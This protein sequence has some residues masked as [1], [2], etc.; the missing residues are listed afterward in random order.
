MLGK[1]QIDLDALERASEIYRENGELNLPKTNHDQINRIL[2]NI[3]QGYERE[4]L[5]KHFVERRLDF[6]TESLQLGYLAVEEQQ[7]EIDGF[8]RELFGEITTI[9]QFFN[10]IYTEHTEKVK[11]AIVSNEF[12][13]EYTI[14]LKDGRYLPIRHIGKKILDKCISIMMSIDT[15][16]Q[17]HLQKE[18]ILERYEL[19]NQAMTE[20]PY[21]MEIPVD[22]NELIS[23]ANTFWWSPQYRQMLGYKDEN[24]FPNELQSWLNILHPEDAD[25]AYKAMMDYLSD[26]S[27]KTDYQAI[28]RMMHK[29]G[30]YYWYQSEGVVKRDIT[31]RPTRLAGTVRNVQHIVEKER[32]AEE[33]KSKIIE[34]TTSIRNIVEGVASINVQAQS[35]AE[36]QEESSK[37]AS[38][39]EIARGKLGEISQFIRTIAEQTNLLGL[40]AAIEAARAGEQGKGFG[41]V[42]NEVRKLATTSKSATGNIE[43]SLEQMQQAI[44]LIVQQMNNL[45]ELTQSQAELTKQVSNS[46]NEVNDASRKIIEFANN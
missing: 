11:E 32:K 34:L 46:A 40:N 19:I 43:Q 30:H 8:I 16:K 2:D 44:V 17:V 41:V 22:V 6:I 36:T 31:G 39:I 28:F 20:A 42:A 29:D 21:E 7:I 23:P 9:D 35:L 1:K 26:Y 45:S 27:G 37:A 18:K 13:I 33:L 25:H 10:L 5:H 4:L 24:D 12:D 3:Q 14:L 38:T 15:H